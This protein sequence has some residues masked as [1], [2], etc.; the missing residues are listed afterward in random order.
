MGRAINK[1]VTIAEI[2]KRRIPGLHQITQIDS[3]DITDVW[4]PLEQGLDR[5]I[6]TRHVSSIQIILSTKQLD[7][8]HV[9]YVLV[10]LYWSFSHSEC[11]LIIGINLLFLLIK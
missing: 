7:I 8:N 3:T 4:E 11:S 10:L 9:G 6:T 1:T 2:I 5:V